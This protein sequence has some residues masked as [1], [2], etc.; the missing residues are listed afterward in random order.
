[1][2]DLD[3]AFD[4]T[5]SQNAE[6][7]FAWYVKAIDANYAPAMTAIDSFLGRVGRGKFLYPLYEE[8]I[9][10]NQRTFAERVFE[11]SRALYHPIA[12]HRIEEI[13]QAAN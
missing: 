12:Q 13:L 2:K 10:A 1:M 11:K 9:K 5:D 8:L 6:I 3:L 4:L 7:A